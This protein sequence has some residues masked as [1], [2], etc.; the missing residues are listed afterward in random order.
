MVAMPKPRILHGGR[1]QAIF[2]PRRHV[3]LAPVATCAIVSGGGR[4]RIRDAGDMQDCGEEATKKGNAT[5][6]ETNENREV[7]DNKADQAG[8]E[9]NEIFRGST[10]SERKN[11]EQRGRASDMGGSRQV[12]HVNNVASGS[13]CGSDRWWM[14]QPRTQGSTRESNGE[15][16]RPWSGEAQ[17]PGS[18]AYSG[19]WTCGDMGHREKDCGVAARQ[20][21]GQWMC[22]QVVNYGEQR[23]RM[24]IEQM[25]G[26][27]V[28][29]AAQVEGS[30]QWKRE[31][32]LQQDRQEKIERELQNEQ[33]RKVQNA[34]QRALTYARK[35][36]VAVRERALKAL[37][38]YDRGEIIRER[39]TAEQAHAEAWR[40][41]AES[42]E[43]RLFAGRMLQRLKAAESSGDQAEIAK[44]KKRA[45]G[46]AAN[47][48]REA[49]TAAAAKVV[50]RQRRAEMS[51]LLT[52]A[53][54][55]EAR[56]AKVVQANVAWMP[57]PR[58]EAVMP[59]PVVDVVYPKPRE[60]KVV[61]ESIHVRQAC[62][63]RRWHDMTQVMQ[64]KYTKAR[65]IWARKYLKKR[66][67]ST[68][69]K[70]RWDRVIKDIHAKEW[71]AWSERVMMALTTA[72]TRYR[73]YAY[74][75]LQTSFTSVEEGCKML[76]GYNVDEHLFY[77]RMYKRA[78]ERYLQQNPN[79]LTE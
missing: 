31:Q 68:R 65:Q 62:V 47:A 77:L 2:V 51:K 26:K 60:V 46:S 13:E 54:R 45:A 1:A 35:T 24:Q 74:V 36:A 29:N 52:A 61:M 7:V 42:R 63:L 75:S 10:T 56:A 25:F 37:E 3:A 28:L 39:L 11:Y 6:I 41:E 19:C 69:Q 16:G 17:V 40:C 5:M 66:E 67:Q 23:A 71:R 12:V 48:V 58:A 9:Q 14:V 50:A 8:Y 30:P 55:R 20:Q 38:A 78:R 27:A 76:R 4:G 72:G 73:M 22:E 49:K 70:G 79:D 32:E 18:E 34:E 64:D 43:M 21:V 44:W 59:G 15:R 33:D 57:Q 53:H